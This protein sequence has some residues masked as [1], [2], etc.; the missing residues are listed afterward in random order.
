MNN[1]IRGKSKYEW[2]MLSIIM[3]FTGLTLWRFVDHGSLAGIPLI[4]YAFWR[5][6]AK[7]YMT[8]K[9]EEKAFFNLLEKCMK[10]LS[11]FND[12]AMFYEVR[13]SFKEWLQK[14]EAKNK[15]KYKT[16][17]CPNC[18]TIIKLESKEKPNLVLC[19]KCFEQ[20]GVK[21]VILLNRNVR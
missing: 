1:E 2:D 20:L 18:R 11:R 6:R 3:G 21:N 9:R 8:R 15:Y 17:T 5:S 4:I 19:P 12:N 14:I 7:N 10:I 13:K 16:M